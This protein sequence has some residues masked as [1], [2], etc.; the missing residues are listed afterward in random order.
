MGYHLRELVK[1]EPVE[2]LCITN[3]FPQKIAKLHNLDSVPIYWLSDIKGGPQNLNPKRLSFEIMQTITKFVKDDSH[4]GVVLLD[5][6]EY[7]V[8]VN[9]FEPVMNFI[10]SINDLASMSGATIMV[11][12]NPDAFEEKELIIVRREFDKVI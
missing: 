2:G 9:G 8:L 10:K 7:L 5:G 6:F 1:E 12:V 11:P 4:E 3:T